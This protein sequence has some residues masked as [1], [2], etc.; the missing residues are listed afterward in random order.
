MSK[1]KRIMLVFLPFF[2]D[3]KLLFE[4]DYLTTCVKVILRS[5]QFLSPKIKLKSKPNYCDNF[6]TKRTFQKRHL[7]WKRVGGKRLLMKQHV[8]IRKSFLYYFVRKTKRLPWNPNINHIDNYR[9][10]Q[11]RYPS[12]WW[13]SFEP[14]LSNCIRSL[15][16]IRTTA[17]NGYFIYYYI[18]IKNPV[19]IT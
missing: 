7:Y 19:Y 1:R 4:N 11:H 8:F 16:S 2:T 5:Y 14:N 10:V 3:L 17:P 18:S 9:N 6:S 12:V 15:L 13:V